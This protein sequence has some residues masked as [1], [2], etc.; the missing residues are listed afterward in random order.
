MKLELRLLV[1]IHYFSN[2]AEAGGYAKAEAG[3]SFGFMGCG[4]RLR[5]CL[6]SHK[7]ATSHD[8]V[9]RTYYLNIGI[10][11]NSSKLIEHPKTRIIRNESILLK[12]ISL[13]SIGN[14]IYIKITFI[15]F[16]YLVVWQ[17]FLPRLNA[18][19]CIFWQRIATKPAVMNYFWYHLVIGLGVDNG[20]SLVRNIHTVVDT[21]T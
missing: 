4:T 2:K 1:I 14:Y 20:Y 18:F 19:F 5:V 9:Q 15:P 11:V 12:S 8:I 10:K 17:K 13:T 21:P 3:V 7:T 16:F 6:T